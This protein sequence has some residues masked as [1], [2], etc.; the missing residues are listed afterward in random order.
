MKENTVKYELATIEN[1]QQ[2][3]KK[4]AKLRTNVGKL[5]VAG[6]AINSNQWKVAIIINNIEEG[7][8]YK[9]DFGTKENFSNWMNFE[10][11][12]VGRMSKAV[13]CMVNTLNDFGL[14]MENTTTSKA[15]CLAGVEKDMKRFVEFIATQGYDIKTISVHD[16]EKLKKEFKNPESKAIENK[17]GEETGKADEKKQENKF[18]G[19]YDDKGVW[20]EVN[21]K[22][23]TILFDELK[24]YIVK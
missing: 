15:Y 4:N 18:T 20:F 14:T 10:G 8:Q 5:L 6:K 23:Y 19:L 17:P 16:I 1:Y 13:R 9:D 7:Q 2:V 11:N 24:K 3:I 12:Y 21:G 22:K